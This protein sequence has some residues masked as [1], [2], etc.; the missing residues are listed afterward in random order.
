MILPPLVLAY[1]F[2][3]F[4]IL[5]SGSSISI[6]PDLDPFLLAALDEALLDIMLWA[7]DVPITYCFSFTVSFVG[8]GSYVISICFILNPCYADI[9]VMCINLFTFKKLFFIY[10]VNITS[11]YLWSI[12]TT[13]P[14][15]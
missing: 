10:P 1:S 2:T 11:F 15:I 9:P 6:D 4:Y 13:F 7:F 14:S 5:N 3:S 8:Q 12:F